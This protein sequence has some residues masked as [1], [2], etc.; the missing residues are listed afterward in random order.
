MRRI[1]AYHFFIPALIFLVFMAFLAA[2]QSMA[3]SNTVAAS[4]LSSTLHNALA[5]D[6]KP[7]ACAHINITSLVICSGSGICRGT[8]NRNL[9]L[10]T[11]GNDTIRAS[12]G[13]D[14]IIGGGGNDDINGQGGNDICIRGPGNSTYQGC[15]VVDP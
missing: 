2:Y 4:R 11:A 14:C 6:L 15:I 13:D 12:N 3:A 1:K 9:I 10:G 5:N 8:G 7:P